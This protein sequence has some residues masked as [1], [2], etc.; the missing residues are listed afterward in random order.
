MTTV[1]CVPE[2]PG[3]CQT[4]LLRLRYKTPTKGK[5]M[6]YSVSEMWD[7]P[8]RMFASREVAQAWMEQAIASE[9][10]YSSEGFMIEEWPLH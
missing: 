3:Q 6:I 4:P 8:I 1:S 9:K 2:H 10:I 5:P 7:G